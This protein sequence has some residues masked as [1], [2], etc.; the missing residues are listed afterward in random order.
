MPPVRLDSSRVKP[1]AAM[2][3]RAFNGDPLV[4]YLL[5]D[6]AS[7]PRALQ[8]GCAC[9]VRYGLLRGEVYAASPAVEAVA[10][11]LPPGAA[12]ASLADMARV[13]MPLL[14]LSTGCGFL[15]RFWNYYR[16][17][18]RCWTPLVHQPFWY[19]QMLGVDPACQRQGHARR[20]LEHVLDRCDRHSV[21]CCLDTAREENVTLYERFGFRLLECATLPGTSVTIWLMSRAASREDPALHDLSK[22]EGL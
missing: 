4:G 19:L 15:R 22:G 12:H 11:W 5:P 3:A 20:L 21:A 6:E 18:E 14:P 13:G 10:V 8:G 1:A 16:H 17:L 2:L 9:L 7:R